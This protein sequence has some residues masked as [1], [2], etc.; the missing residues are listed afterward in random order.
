MDRVLDGPPWVVGKHAVLL[1][2]FNVDLKPQDMV[3]N[4]LRVWVRLINLPFGYMQNK[5]GAVIAR[6][7]CVDGSVPEVD[8]DAT[9]RCWGSYMRVC[10]EIDVNE[11]LRRGVTVFSQRHKVT[12][13]FN[14][15]YECLPHYCH[16]CGVLGHSSIECK[17]PGERDEDGKLPYSSDRVL[18]PD[19]RKNKFQGAKSSSGSVSTGQGRASTPMKERPDQSLNKNGAAGKQQ[20]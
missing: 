6:P 2:G 9:G 17:N 4:K 10:I 12:E 19:E 5:W 8:C 15:Q 3:F 1:Q 7:L 20:T 11:P 16:S 18:A 14:I 13:W